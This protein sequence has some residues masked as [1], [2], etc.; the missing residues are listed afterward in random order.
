MK[1][2]E[3]ELPEPIKKHE[4]LDIIDPSKLQSF[5]DCPRGFFFSY[6]LGWR[7]EEPNRHLAFGSAWHDAMEFILQHRE[8]LSKEQLIYGAYEA[9]NKV[10]RQEYPD[11]NTDNMRAPKTPEFALQG[12]EEYVNT[13]SELDKIETMFTEV[14]GAV[15]IAENRLLHTKLDAIIRDIPT[16]YIWSQE[17]KTTGR[18][19]SSWRDKW[20]FILQV[21][22]YTHLLHCAFP[23]ESIGGVII[24]GAVFTK[25]RGVEFIRKPINKRPEDMQEAIWELNHWWDQLE[26]NMNEL[27]KCSESDAVMT[28]FPRNGQSCSKFGCRYPGFCAAWKNPLQRAHEPPPGYE[29]N[30]WDPR[31]DE[32]GKAKAKAEPKEDGKVEIKKINKEEQTTT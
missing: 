7:Q 27:S 30:H 25:S 13:Y 10:Y 28:A 16:G 6:I 29:I 21:S 22:A 2:S 4:T 17:H 31:R 5:Q 32:E 18:N 14:I 9:F 24:N 1:F 11:P 8:N 23:E 12:I 19:S 26:W 3:Y 20:D 15:P